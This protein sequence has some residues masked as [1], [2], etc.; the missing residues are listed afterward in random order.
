MKITLGYYDMNGR[1][2]GTNVQT[3]VPDYYFVSG[4]VRKKICEHPDVSPYKR[5]EIKTH[6]RT[7]CD[8]NRLWIEIQE[9]KNFNRHSTL[10]N[11]SNWRWDNEDKKHKFQII[12]AVMQ[13]LT[14]T[15]LLEIARKYNITSQRFIYFP[16]WFEINYNALNNALN[17][18]L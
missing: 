15:K 2:L 16:G 8:Q 6:T 10:R 9:Y 13:H 18:Q 7:Y 5:K 14:D 3:S 17:P 11:C 1:W 4:T 12:N